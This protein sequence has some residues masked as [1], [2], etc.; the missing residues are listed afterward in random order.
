MRRRIPYRVCRCLPNGIVTH[1]EARLLRELVN[2]EIH[3]IRCA[4]SCKRKFMKGMRL[5]D[6][7][8]ETGHFHWALKVWELTERLIDSKDWD[9][10][11]NVHFNPKWYNLTD[12]ISETECELLIKRC[13]DLRKALGYPKEYWWSDKKEHYSK[14]YFGQ[15]YYFL[16]AE[17]NYGYY[18]FEDPEEYEEEMRALRNWYKTEE[19]YHEG[20]TDYLP[21]GSQSYTEYWHDNN[22]HRIIDDLSWFDTS[23]TKKERE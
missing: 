9:D 11:I 21:P 2:R 5:G 8:A 18:F 13:C 1:L 10:W 3:P 16:F 4:E 15:Q 19:L 6:L 17:K 22:R 23:F 7:C 14:R 20:M 12:V